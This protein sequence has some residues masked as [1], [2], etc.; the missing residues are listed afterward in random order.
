MKDL[1]AAAAAVLLFHSAPSHAAPPAKKPVIAVVP[2]A[3]AD[4]ELRKLGLLMAARASELLEQT[5]KYAELHVKQIVAMAEAEGIPSNQLTELWATQN[6][7]QV[8]GADRVVAVSLEKKGKGIALSGNVVTSAKGPTPF[9]ADLKADWTDALNAGSEAIA[10]AV[11]AQDKG[12]LP[13]SPSAQP[14]SKSADALKALA[15]CYSVVI[16]QPLGVEAP[17]VLLGEEM[18]AAAD[19]CAAALKADANLHFASATQA[20][21]HALLGEDAEATKV[22]NSLGEGTDVI[23]PTSLARFFQVTRFQS[24]EAG[25]KVLDATIKKHPGE[26]IALNYKADTLAQ[27]EEHQ[28]AAD[29]WKAY[30]D[31]VPN[32]PF[33]HGRLS[34]ALAR[35]GKHDDAIAA[36][37]KAME[38]AP[39]SLEAR[40]QLGSRYIDANKLDDAIATLK[41]LAD[42]KS[43]NGEHVARLGWA[44]WLKGNVEGAEPLFKKA[45]ELSQGIGQWRTRGRTLYNLAMI[46]AKRGKKDAAK[47]LLQQSLETGFKVRQPDALVAS[48]LKTLGDAKPAPK[49][50]SAL[51]I[52]AFGDVDPK[53]KKPAPPEGFKLYED[54]LK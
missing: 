37:K 31:V 29:A 51:P 40:L 44:H 19:A 30:L 47:G 45:L 36:A 1:L 50:A 13:K 42:A 9:K 23:E 17:S 54:D 32:S 2:P 49:E 16:R 15:D 43:P 3:S 48:I 27:L 6:A 26:L 20:L 8:L 22:L 41:P 24:N 18:D 14:E 53:A 46:E 39:D 38:L 5:N 11:L 4:E 34:R 12:S 28:K 25:L 7:R 35:L 21:A 33:G 52:D 10:K